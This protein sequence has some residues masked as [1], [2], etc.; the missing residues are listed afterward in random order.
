MKRNS[1][2]SRLMSLSCV[3]LSGA[4][5]AEPAQNSSASSAP[6]LRVNTETGETQA[7][8]AKRTRWWR[9]GKFGMFVHWGVYSV[10]NSD[11]SNA[12]A[13]GEWYLANMG[14]QPAE[15]EKFAA[16]FNPTK[17]SAREWV[18]IAKAAGMKYITITAKHHDGFDMFDSKLSNYNIVQATPYH[19]DPMKDLA[20]E[21]KKQGIRLCFYYSVKDWDRYDYL[22]RAAWDKR[23][24]DGADL[25]R[26][27]EY[28][29]G[30]VREL[31]TNYGP[32]GGIWFDGHLDHSAEEEHALEVVKMIRSI[33]PNAMVN[34]R[35]N[36]PEDYDTPENVIPDKG[37][38]GGRLWETC[39]TING[40][41]GY[42]WNDPHFKSSQTLIRTL[43]DVVGKGGNLLLNVGPD[44]SG[45]I[46]AE[47]VSRLQEIGA[48]MDVN[49]DS[50]YGTTKN[51][52]A[53]L[54][55][56]GRCTQKGDTLYLQ[57]YQW[58]DAG[59]T[60]PHLLTPV[61]EAVALNGRE[62]LAVS[63][64]AD[65]VLHIAKPSR[66]DPSSTVIALHLKGK[67]VIDPFSRMIQPQ[68]DGAYTLTATDAEIHGT[69]ARLESADN[70]DDV[71]YWTNLT[72]NVS[73]TLAV[74]R[75]QAGKYKV[76]LEF[77]CPANT[78][79]GQYEIAIDGQPDNKIT[80]AAGVTANWDT[81][82]T[83]NLEG[84]LTLSGDHATLR[85]SPK[86]MPALGILNLRRLTLTRVEE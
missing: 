51:P 70:I 29:K 7:Q 14:M 62:R 45:T 15:Y 53:S 48:W 35:I 41:W 27:I 63:K 49:G 68:K 75:A 23:P 32:I 19:H 36:L 26:Y 33:Q 30:Q 42:T 73:W 34:D 65:G 6:Q 12:D 61:R 86:T 56:E 52:F 3:L 66:L 37:L 22:P 44:S 83:V 2:I 60:L 55:Y 47:E 85:M 82:A 5:H 64:D 81:F 46:P 72:D 71:G 4:A 11:L 10:P 80:G 69:T 40:H 9:D 16:K 21:C 58:P 57:V 67:P 78:T 54:P 25:D 28:L 74:P 18:S 1:R 24:T 31:L 79:G 59:L 20:A 8:F 13:S 84:T 50:I 39:L 77:A 76:T 17:F 38:P 43:C